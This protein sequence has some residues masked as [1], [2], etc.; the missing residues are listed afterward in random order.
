MEQPAKLFTV[1]IVVVVAV[2]NLVL[3]DDA[4]VGYGRVASLCLE[5]QVHFKVGAQH[6]AAVSV[7]V[8][9]PD[10]LG[11]DS[12]HSMKIYLIIICQLR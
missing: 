5:F 6:G 4:E 3:A 1:V 12:R 10:C 8:S 9:G 11:L 2:G 7:I